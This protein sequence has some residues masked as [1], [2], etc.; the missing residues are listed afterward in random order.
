MSEGAVTSRYT[1]AANLRWFAVLFLLASLA[2]SFVAST[3]AFYVRSPALALAATFGAFAFSAWIAGDRFAEKR[4]ADVRKRRPD[5]AI[6]YVIVAATIIL[7]L[8]VFT[9]FS[10]IALGGMSVGP[11]VSH[12]L[13]GTI[14]G[15]LLATFIGIIVNYIV[16]WFIIGSRR[17]GEETTT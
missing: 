1:I 17:A 15:A 9:I 4:G 6:G 8:P 13:L 11:E 10:M 3:F 7:A 5:L 14:F 2:A 12:N 16:A